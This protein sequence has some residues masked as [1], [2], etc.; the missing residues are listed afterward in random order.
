MVWSPRYDRGVLPDVIKMFPQKD[1]E[2]ALPDRAKQRREG[3][4]LP[5]AYIGGLDHLQALVRYR[6]I[7]TKILALV[8]VDPHE[9]LAHSVHDQSTMMPSISGPLILLHYLDK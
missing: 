1:D 8:K 4:G 9:V 3:V 5:R 6:C 2:I 7:V